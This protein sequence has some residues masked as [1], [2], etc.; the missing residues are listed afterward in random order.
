MTPLG[1]M[2][3]SRFWET[4]SSRTRGSHNRPPLS[5]LQELSLQELCTTIRLASS[6]L[7]LDKRALRN[8]ARGAFPNLSLTNQGEVAAS[9]ASGG[10]G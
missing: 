1:L 5:S 4:T 3:A 6:N 10:R 9:S 7:S 8:P 2:S